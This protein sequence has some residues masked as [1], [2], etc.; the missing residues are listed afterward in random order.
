MNE[1]EIHWL[2]KALREACGELEEYF[3]DIDRDESVARPDDDEPTLIEIAARLRDNEEQVIGWLQLIANSGRR[4]P[5]LPYVNIDLL[6]FERDYSRLQVRKVLREFTSLR[7]QTVHLLWSLDTRDWRR[8]GIH[9]YRGAITVKDIVQEL[10]WHD[11]RYLWEVR[12][13]LGRL[14]RVPADI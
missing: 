8:R 11:L 7:R 3:Y 6:P 12:R 10:N 4:E 2:L 1:Q 9:P 14:G 13:L 5:S